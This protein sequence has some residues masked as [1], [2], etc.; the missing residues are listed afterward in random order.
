MIKNMM[1][2]IDWLGRIKYEDEGVKNE[3]DQE[4]KEDGEDK[5][6]EE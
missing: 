4:D 3:E 6:D 5:E 1:K 2:K